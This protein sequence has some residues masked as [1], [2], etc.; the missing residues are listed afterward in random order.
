MSSLLKTIK[1]I[2][3]KKKEENIMTPRKHEKIGN[4]NLFSEEISKNII[5]KIISLVITYNFNKKSDK[6][7]GDFC[8]ASMRKTINNIIKLCNINHD[9][10]DFDIDNIEI[11]T[12]IKTNKSDNDMKRYLIKNI[13]MQ[14]KQETIKPK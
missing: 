4:L 13:M 9:K 1:K 5:E 8:F 3:K 14:R 11:N 6:K 7:I 10:D 2:K 12:Y